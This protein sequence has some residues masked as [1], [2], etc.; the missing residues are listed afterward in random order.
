MSVQQITAKEKTK[1]LLGTNLFLSAKNSR[2]SEL[3]LFRLI[4]SY[5]IGYEYAKTRFL[6]N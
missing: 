6:H 3:L 4:K 1:R 5:S 2:P